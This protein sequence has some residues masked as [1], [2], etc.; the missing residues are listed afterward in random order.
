MSE[1]VLTYRGASGSAIPVEAEPINPDLFKDKN[2]AAIE[3]LPVHHGNERGTLADFFTIVGE[4][5]D[6]IRVEGD[7]SRV[8][9]I[10]AGMSSGAILIE[11]NAGMHVGAEMSGGT[12]EVHGNVD[13]W[14]GAEMTGGLL[15]IRG[16]AGNRTGSAYRGSKYGMRGGVVLVEGNAGHEIGGYMRRGLIAVRGDVL[17]HTGARMSAGSVFVFGSA[18]IRTGGGMKR[19]T[20]V[21]Y[22]KPE[23]LPTFKFNATYTPHFITIYLRALRATGFP[24][25]KDADRPHPF[26]RYNGDLAELG[27]GE[28]LVAQE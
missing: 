27:K 21:C 8:K 15:R 4:R 20:I 24:I 1:V 7:L 23:I 14:A 26:A 17:D 16:N 28:I 3:K 19:G 22:K 12:I 18:G 10:G 25:P 9:G 13:D 11:G 2:R 5:S 6:A